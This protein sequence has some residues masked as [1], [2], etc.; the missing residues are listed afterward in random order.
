MVRVYVGIS[1]CK[2]GDMSTNEPRSPGRPGRRPSSSRAAIEEAAGELFLEQSY[3]RT[4]IEHITTR[5]GVSR[6]SFFNYFTAKSD[7]LWGDV[8][9]LVDSVELQL[10]AQPRDIPPMKAVRGALVSAADTVGSDRIPLAVTQWE[11]MGARD[12]L[13]TSGLP[14]FSRLGAL[15]RAYLEGRALEGRADPAQQLAIASA[16]FAL[17]G[18]VAA[19]AA[20]WAAQG[21][22]RDP[23]APIID[24]AIAPVCDGFASSFA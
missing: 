21:T 22:S 15:V 19:A 7:L 17:V 23:L 12:E 16:S 9:A 20:T 18:A 3:A 13:L 1:V 11:L 2:S 6:A 4:T 14:R 10:R 5:A 24:Q 8:D